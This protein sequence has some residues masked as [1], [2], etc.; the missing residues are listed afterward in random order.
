MISDILG[1]LP[2]IGKVIAED[3]DGNL[4]GGNPELVAEIANDVYLQDEPWLCPCRE[5]VLLTPSLPPGS[6]LIGVDV[7]V[8]VAADRARAGVGAVFEVVHVVAG[9]RIAEHELL[10]VVHFD[11]GRELW[12]HNR[13]WNAE[14]PNEQTSP[15]DILNHGLFLHSLNRSHIDV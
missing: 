8:M 2:S 15:A 7:L 4:F 11:Q 12:H 5:T 3:S 10:A 14:K 13:G 1:F 9:P 6:A